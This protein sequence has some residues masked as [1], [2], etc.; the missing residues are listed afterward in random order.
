MSEVA[1]LENRV[2]RLENQITAGFER[3]EN[4]LRQEINDLKSEQI[5]M[6]R[7]ENKR[8]ADDQRRVWEAVRSLEND[9]NKAHGGGRVFTGLM[10]GLISILGS[11]AAAVF[12]T[13]FLR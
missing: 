7:E 10:T 13:K 5:N 1:A 8:L 3:L 2:N 12:I 11:S 4:L 9:R 6:L